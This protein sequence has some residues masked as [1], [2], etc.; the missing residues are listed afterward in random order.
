MPQH[1]VIDVEN[2]KDARALAQ[3]FSVSLVVLQDPGPEGPPRVRL[4]G[5]EHNM[6]IVLLLMDY[7]S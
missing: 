5:H 1:A 7:D 6:E 2:L 4:M 3:Q